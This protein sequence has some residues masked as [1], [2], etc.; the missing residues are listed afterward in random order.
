MIIDTMGNPRNLA[1]KNKPEKKYSA[2]DK[3]VLRV[4]KLMSQWKPGKCN[5]K[6]VPVRLLFPMSIDPG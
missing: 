4:A 6:K 2:L 3:E 5:G 1:I